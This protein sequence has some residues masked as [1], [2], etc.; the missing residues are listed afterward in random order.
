MVRIERIRSW[1]PDDITIVAAVSAG[2]A[3]GTLQRE[4]R[5]TYA[6]IMLDHDLQQQA[7]TTADIALSGA[8]LIEHIIRRSDKRTAILV[9]SANASGARG[10]AERLD[11]AGFRVTQIPMYQLTESYFRNWLDE[12]REEWLDRFYD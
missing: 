6:G 2:R 1:L 7:A 4:G 5:D 9:H 8:Q 10:M 12:V 11:R 3:I